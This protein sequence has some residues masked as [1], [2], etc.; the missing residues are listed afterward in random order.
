MVRL[1]FLSD[2]IRGEIFSPLSLYNYY[3]GIKHMGMFD[4]IRSSYDLGPGFWNKELQ[5]KDLDNIMANYWIDPAGH[6]FEVDYSGTR[7][8]D[9]QTTP[10]YRWNV[11]PN[12]NHGK[13]KP[14]FY[15]GEIEVYPSQWTAYYSAFPRMKIKFIDGVLQ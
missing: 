5:T 10:E 2:N 6:L 15:S 4:T 13:V 11:V 9:I 3:S 1:K 14:I 7:D 8:F 12:G